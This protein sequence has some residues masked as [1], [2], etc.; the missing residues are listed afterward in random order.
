MTSAKTN[1]GIKELSDFLLTKPSNAQKSAQEQDVLIDD[2]KLTLWDITV[3]KLEYALTNLP[4]EKKAAMQ[5]QLSIL[6]TSL[7]EN[8]YMNVSP[9]VNHFLTESQTILEDKHPSIMKKVLKLAIVAVVTILAALVGFGIGFAAGLWTGPGAFITGF[10][11]GSTAAVSVATASIIAGGLTAHGLFK[12]P[13]ELTTAK[14][15]ADEIK[16]RPAI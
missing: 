7:R 14:H 2:C 16:A 5:K 11:A 4:Q 3:S 12:E 8:P 15:F 6:K 9:A 1:F 13:K 10:M